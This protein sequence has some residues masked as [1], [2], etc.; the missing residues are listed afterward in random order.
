MFGSKA[1]GTLFRT[2]QTGTGELQYSPPDI[3]ATRNDRRWA[4]D[5]GIKAGHQ[6]IAGC[7]VC[8]L[9]VIDGQS[10]HSSDFRHLE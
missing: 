3:R 7:S 4:V 2:F 9:P 6:L 1:A 5:W 10:I 8:D